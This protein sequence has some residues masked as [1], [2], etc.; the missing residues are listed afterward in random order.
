VR[1]TLLSI[2]EK[3]ELIEKNPQPQVRLRGFGDSSLNF[4]LLCWIS[5]PVL[6][7][8]ASDQVYEAI[9]NIFKEKDIKIPYPVM[10][11]KLK[12]AE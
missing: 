11:V 9:Y 5:E 7:G 8:R 2:V 6:R 4:E 3:N 10:D 12:K 1:D